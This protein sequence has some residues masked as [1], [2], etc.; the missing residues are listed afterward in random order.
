MIPQ[1]EGNM[2]WESAH[3]GAAIAADRT[4]ASI[5]WIAP[6]REDDAEAQIALVDRVAEGDYQG[7]VLAPDQALSLI[8]P[9][10]RV[11]AHHIPTVVISSPLP[12]PAGGDLSYILNDD[13]LGGQIA[14]KRV[15]GLLHGRGSVAVLG[16]DPDVTGTVIRDHVFEEFLATNDPEIH[17]VERRTGSFNF[18]HEQQA[19]EDV[20]RKH[21]DLDVIVA[22]MATS[23]D[24]TLSALRASSALHKPRVVGF[25]IGGL[26]SFEQN[27]G[28]DCVIQ[29]DSHAMGEKAIELIEAKRH[30]QPVPLMTRIPPRII[31]QAN[32]DSQQIRDMLAQDWTLGHLHWSPIQ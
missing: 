3:V 7:L 13:E 5:Y 12:I 11:L 6:M 21:P 18:P 25:D 32:V 9:V 19:A 26:P 16:I 15:A 2:I 24:G 22:L 29:G 10:R 4:G 27:P 30:G 20:A 23:V 8:S 31:T 14:A 1:T 17:I 28:L